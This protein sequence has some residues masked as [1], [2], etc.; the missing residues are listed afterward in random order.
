[1]NIIKPQ[2]YLTIQGWMVTDLHLKGNE[3]LVYAIIYGFTQAEGEQFT[4]SLSYLCEWTQ[5]TKQG[6]Q[7]N[8][9]SLTEKGLIEKSEIY[10]GG[11]R[12][13]AYHTTELHSFEDEKVDGYTTEFNGV[14]NSVVQGMQLSCPNNKE[15]NKVDNIEFNFKEKKIE[16]EKKVAE[17]KQPEINGLR[18]G[19]VAK[20]GIEFE[21]FWNAYPNQ[22][23]KGGA[24]AKYKARLKE[25]FPAD[26]L[27][28]SAK[29]Y[30]AECKR[31][32]T[33][34]HYILHAATFLGPSLRF[35]EYGDFKKKPETESK[36]GNPFENYQRGGMLAKDAER[37]GLL[38]T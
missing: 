22:K 4:G 35:T 12:H 10:F 24:F 23:D 5:S 1:M 29:D 21:L 3:L 31:Q 27:L 18:K 7:K 20:Y 8:L 6:I 34:E 2:N 17:E 11:V 19:Q 30:A 15:D 33:E 38:D 16:K 32:H 9:K 26:M 25:G 37:L 36:T 14:Y 13:V 28:S